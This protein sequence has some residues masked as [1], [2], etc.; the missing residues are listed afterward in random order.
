MYSRLAIK[1]LFILTCLVSV[2]LCQNYSA[3]D[4]LGQKGFPRAQVD[5]LIRYKVIDKHALAASYYEK[6]SIPKLAAYLIEPAQNDFEKARAI[7]RWVCDNI[8]YDALAYAT[9]T[10][11]YQSTLTENVLK[12]GRTVCSGYSSIFGDLATEA[13]LEV[14]SI[15]GIAKG[16]GYKLGQ[17]IDESNHAWNAVKLDGRWYFIEST[18]GAGGV[19]GTRFIKKFKESYFLPAPEVF[20]YSHFPDNPKWQ[21]LEK[22]FDLSDFQTSPHV[23]CKASILDVKGFEKY[24]GEILVKDTVDLVFNCPSDVYLSSYISLASGKSISGNFTFVKRGEDGIHVFARFPG[25]G[26]YVLTINGRTH[27]DHSGEHVADYIVKP[28][29]RTS[30]PDPFPRTHRAYE[31][32]A[33]SLEYPMQGR[34]RRGSST[35]FKIQ[36]PKAEQVAV[37]LDDEWIKLERV[38]ETFSGKV[39]LDLKG[40][41]IILA[42]RFEGEEVYDKLVSYDVR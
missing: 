8:K 29:W 26:R 27:K 32:N 25:A 33:V 10:I 6:S 35:K 22:P 30:M 39:I 34:L 2:G 41:S 3:K 24:S 17:K 20:V 19:S 1:I 28:D 37:I 9:N 21:L 14:V 15:G 7:Y 31:N 12:T 23:R 4:L 38:K 18:W 36:V 11:T 40:S 16:A 13:G 5:S 42:A